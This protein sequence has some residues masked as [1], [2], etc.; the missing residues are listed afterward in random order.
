MEPNFILVPSLDPLTP[1]WRTFPELRDVL[2]V[3]G[4]PYYVY[5]QFASYLTSDREDQQ[6]WQRAYALFDSLAAGDGDLMEIL[7]FGLFEALCVDPDVTERVKANV[8][9]AAQKLLD[10]MQAFWRA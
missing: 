5:A 1:L 3:D 2:D 9:L 6:L 7:A 8:G 4:G 10:D